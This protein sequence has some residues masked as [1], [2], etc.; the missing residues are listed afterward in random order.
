MN[1]T[2]KYLLPAVLIALA[3]PSKADEAQ[4]ISYNI[5]TAAVASGGSHTPSWLVSNKHGLAS[6]NP[7][8]GYLSAGLFRDFDQTKGFTWAY[9]LE[10][11]GAWNHSAPLIVQQFYGDIKY[12]CWELSIGSKERYSEGKYASASTN[13]HRRHGSSTDGYK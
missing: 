9:G 10:L 13:M 4:K 11:T 3:S 6:L 5:E 1:K 8:N 12:N 7:N 2:W